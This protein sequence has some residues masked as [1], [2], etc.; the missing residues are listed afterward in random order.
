MK[1]VLAKILILILLIPSFAIANQDLS[2]IQNQEFKKIY[3][4]D[5]INKILTNSDKKNSQPLSIGYSFIK[6]EQDNDQKKY[7]LINDQQQ[8]LIS[9]EPSY[10]YNWV[11]QG[12]EPECFAN[13]QSSYCF[14]DQFEFES[15]GS[16]QKN[17]KKDNYKY[18]KNDDR[19]YCET[20]SYLSY[21][22]YFVKDFDG[23]YLINQDQILIQACTQ[24]YQKISRNFLDPNNFCKN[25]KRTIENK[26]FFFDC[27]N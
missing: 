8:Y 24:D 26:K 5:E 17:L 23:N 4:G 13:T 6:A 1:I 10:N 27:I 7:S 16:F 15:K 3:L 14:C 11:G 21:D 20:K 25:A 18:L 12:D 2:S 19:F 22:C 9:S